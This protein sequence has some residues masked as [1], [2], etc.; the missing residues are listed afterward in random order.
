MPMLLAAIGSTAST[1]TDKWGTVF[2]CFLL[3]GPCK[4]CNPSNAL[5]VCQID[6][7]NRCM[8]SRINV[9][10]RTAPTRMPP[11]YSVVPMVV[12]PI[13]QVLLVT[14]ALSLLVAFAF[15]VFQ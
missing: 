9:V 15:T 3:Q 14:P 6:S 7:D 10:S 1:P 8:P 5:K 11:L 13:D 12:V 4:R 2:R